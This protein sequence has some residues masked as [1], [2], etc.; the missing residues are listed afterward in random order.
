MDPAALHAPAPEGT[1]PFVPAYSYAM[2]PYHPHMAP[3]PH[4]ALAPQTAVPAPQ[5]APAPRA[6]PAPQTAP[7][8]PPPADE[9]RGAVRLSELVAAGLVTPGPGALTCECYDASGTKKLFAADLLADGLIEDGNG[10]THKSPSAWA[11]ACK[12]VPANGWQLVKHGGKSLSAY[13]RKLGRP[14]RRAAGPPQPVNAFFSYV[15]EN[16]KAASAGVG[17]AGKHAVSALAQSWRSMG[18]AEKRPFEEISRLS[19]EAYARAK[20]AMGG[21]APR[22]AAHRGGGSPR[23]GKCARTTKATLAEMLAAGLVAPGA[24][25]ISLARRPDVAADLRPGGAIHYAGATYATP[26]GFATAVAGKPCSGFTTVTYDGAS[27]ADI[28]DRGAAPAA[29]PRVPP[30]PAEEEEPEVAPHVPPPPVEADVAPHVPPPP[31]EEEEPEVAAAP[32]AAPAAAEEPHVPAEA[33]EV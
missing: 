15:K 22:A 25:V 24:G 21:K 29:A 2:Y 26:S 9:V 18:A 31:A 7:P 5:M 30:P 11:S 10:A 4:M 20:V 27:L 12:G 13:R 16:F 33:R 32:L 14:A 17:G 3:H 23:G 1:A 8:P 28:R 6:A 19:S